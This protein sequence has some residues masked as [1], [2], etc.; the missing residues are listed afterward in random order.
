MHYKRFATHCP[1]SNSKL[2]EAHFAAVLLF[3]RA[4][5]RRPRRGKSP[6]AAAAAAAAA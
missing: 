2:I 6:P 3:S 4:R 5:H 1:Y